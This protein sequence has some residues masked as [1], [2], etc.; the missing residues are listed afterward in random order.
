VDRQLK[1]N[2]YR[3][4]PEQVECALL[5]RDTITEAAVVPNPNARGEARLTAWIVTERPQVDTA[6]ALRRWLLERMPSYMVPAR[7]GFLAE[8]PTTRSGKVDRPALAARQS[9]VRSTALSRSAPD[10]RDGLEYQLRVLWH[11]VLERRGIG[12]S[13]DFFD[14]GGDS[15]Q[16][17]EMMVG[18]ERLFGAVPSLAEFVAA[19]TIAALVQ[20]L[21]GKRPIASYR[22]LVPMRIGGDAPPFFCVHPMS[23]S[24][25]HFVNLARHF[26]ASRSFYAL[27]AR[28]IDGRGAP[29]ASVEEMAADYLTEIRRKQPHGP[30]HIGGLCLG[31]DVAV[32]MARV[33]LAAGEEVAIVAVFDTEGRSKP[34]EASGW[35]RLKRAVKRL[36]QARTA[37]PR[38]LEESYAWRLRQAGKRYRPEPFPG[39][40]TLFTTDAGRAQSEQNWGALTEGRLEIESIPGEHSTAMR[41]PHVRVVAERLEARLAQAS[42][43]ALDPGRGSIGRGAIL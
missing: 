16:L 43:G 40:V 25:L 14:L 18:I 8:L 33:L 21:R 41:E 22:Y 15:L 29:H 30:Y 20:Q 23:G 39:T 35:K 6:S 19:P 32:E 4:E 7:F 36:R 12:T 27:Q 10:A 31:A 38:E 5:A 3:V 2:G 24:A 11:D 13:D 1:V 9:E 17:A 28:G 26:E 37:R 34:K 42:L